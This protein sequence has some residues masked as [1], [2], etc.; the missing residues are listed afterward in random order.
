MKVINASK[1]PQEIFLNSNKLSAYLLSISTNF[2]VEQSGRYIRVHGICEDL[3]DL[4]EKTGGFGNTFSFQ[5]VPFNNPGQMTY[6]VAKSGMTVEE[7]MAA[8]EAT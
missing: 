1:V 2:A 3:E 8:I 6:I 7:V 5:D 4:C